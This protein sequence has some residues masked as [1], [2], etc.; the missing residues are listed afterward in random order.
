M[1]HALAKLGESMNVYKFQEQVDMSS[2]RM[3]Y[4]V[5]SGQLSVSCFGQAW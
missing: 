3:I 1:C 5:L 2:L 4:K